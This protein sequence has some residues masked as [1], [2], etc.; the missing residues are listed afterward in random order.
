MTNRRR[1][2]EYPFHTTQP[3]DTQAAYYIKARETLER[4]KAN[5]KKS[6]LARLLNVFGI[7]R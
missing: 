1:F 2:G 6:K 3:I 4:I 5:K 7:T